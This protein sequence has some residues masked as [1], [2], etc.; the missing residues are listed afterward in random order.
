MKNLTFLRLVS[1][2]LLLAPVA[3][4]STTWYVD[5]VNGNDRNDCKTRQTACKTIKHAIYL[6]SPGDSIKVAPATYHERLVINIGL[7]I[8]GSGANTTIFDGQSLGIYRVVQVSN[9]LLPVTISN[10]TIRNAD[11]GGGIWNT[12]VLTIIDSVITG[13][14][15]YGACLFRPCNHYGGGIWNDGG[16]LTIIATS[17]TGNSA[18]TDCGTPGCSGPDMGG[19]IYNVGGTLT[20]YNSTIAG[21]TVGNIL[22]SNASL[23]HETLAHEPLGGGIYNAGTGTINNSTIESNIAYDN[24][25][26]GGIYNQYMLAI[27]NGTITD[28]IVDGLGLGG[29]IFNNFSST[30]IL[31]NSIV[32]NSPSGGNCAGTIDSSGYNLSSDGTCNFNNAGDLNNVDPLLGPLE[33]NGGPTYTQALLPRSPAIDAGNPSGCTDEQG[34]LLKIDQRGYPRP[35]KEDTGGCDMGAYERQSD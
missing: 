28:N 19:G 35:D 31:Q 5:G 9:T 29:G 20:I 14:R 11:L 8:V 25:S 15:A 17:V 18:Y 10:V 34:H 12:G 33:N 16:T 1:V 32:A 27:S 23:P 21:N 3:V 4:A 13:N 22:R 7:K 24:G 2:L 6:A 30:T 26:G